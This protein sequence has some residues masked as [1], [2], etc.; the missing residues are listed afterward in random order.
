MHP[1]TTESDRSTGAERMETR[2]PILHSSEMSGC[3]G[4]C[5][6][7]TEAFSLLSNERRALAVWRVHNSSGPLDAGDLAESIGSLENGKGRVNVT[8]SERKSIYVTLTQNHLS[9]LED[10]GVIRY[11]AQSKELS[12]GVH[13]SCLYRVLMAVYDELD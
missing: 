5:I 6:N 1:D 8:A 2:L 7:P 3:D 12:A 10:A 13:L 4:D 11:D 9:K